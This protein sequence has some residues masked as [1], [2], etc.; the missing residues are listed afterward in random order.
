MNIQELETVKRLQLPIK[1]F[2][3]NN[4]G[5]ASIR[6]SQQNYFQHLVAAD[7]TSGLTLP[8][9]RKIAEA[10]G[11]TSARIDNQNDLREQI[12]AVLQMPGPVVCEVVSPPEEQRAPRLS[13]MQRPDGSMV[14]KPLEDLWP[15]LD[16]EEFKANMI[17]PV[18]EE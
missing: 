11:L 10:Y 4:D 1:F 18:L 14:S 16:R 7:R 8:D 2:V 9:L 6:T 15:F 13:S 12:R 5:Y 3:V 17:V